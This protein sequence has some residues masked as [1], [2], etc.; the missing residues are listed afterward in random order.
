MLLLDWYRRA[1]RALPWRGETDPYRIWLSEVMLQQTTVAAVGQR[2]HRFLARFPDLAALAA[3]P[4]EEVAAEW[5]GLGYYARARHLHAAARAMVAAGGFPRDAAGLCALP[6]IGPY[7]AA[8]VA[9]IAFGEPVVPVDANVERVMARLFGIDRP[10]PGARR[11]LAA[12]A[13]GFMDQPAARAAAGDFAQALFDLGAGLCT[14]RAPDCA[15]CPW[16]DFCIARRSGRAAELP[17]RQEK[18]PRSRLFGI[19]FLLRDAAGR[20]GVRQRPPAGLFGGMW[21]LPGTPWRAAPWA[22]AEALA[23]APVSAAPWQPA[24]GEVVH[25]LTHRELRLRLM[26]A[27]APALPPGLSPLPAAAALPSLMR[28]LLALA[29]GEAGSVRSGKR[30]H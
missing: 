8:A 4:W 25:L 28:R 20:I 27:E 14:P 3:A 15:P 21:E 18:R 16:H 1:R 29:E 5:A 17:L 22:E 13:Q 30:R 26:V 2:Y 9:A 12:L 10:L 23:H 7:T 19:H 6:G 24:A 11:L